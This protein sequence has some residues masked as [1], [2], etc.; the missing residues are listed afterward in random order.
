MMSQ[1]DFIAFGKKLSGWKTAGKKELEKLLTL[2]KEL[3]KKN[4]TT[5]DEKK[6]LQ[7]K[8]S[9]IKNNYLDA[10]YTDALVQKILHKLNINPRPYLKKANPQFIVL[11]EEKEILQS[12]SA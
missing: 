2:Q 3:S 5:S 6:D 9:N 11:D 4:T 12:L 10:R 1:D 7:K 8:I